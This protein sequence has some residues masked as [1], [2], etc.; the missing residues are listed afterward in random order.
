TTEMAHATGYWLAR[1][2]PL[3]EMRAL[4]PS[5]SPAAMARIPMLL[6]SAQ[7][8]SAGWQRS[9]QSPL[10]AL[11]APGAAASPGPPSVAPGA[12]PVKLVPCPSAPDTSPNFRPGPKQLRESPPDAR[13]PAVANTQE[14]GNRSAGIRRWL[15]VAPRARLAA[16]P[17]A[18]RSPDQPAIQTS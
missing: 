10:V 4:S 7:R 9:A 11:E 5:E 3:A 12:A 6:Q 1:V 13:P 14:A 8:L 15:S 16:Q 18:T 17:V 2:V